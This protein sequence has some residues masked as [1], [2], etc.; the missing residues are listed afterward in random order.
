MASESSSDYEST[1]VRAEGR[2]SMG[3]GPGP[4]LQGG[5][6]GGTYDGMLEAR[7]ARL[8]AD[9][10]HIKNDIGDLKQTLRS[11]S[12][13]VGSLRVDVA[14][15]TERVDHLPSKG[16]IITVLTVTFALVI[17]ALTIMS[18]TGFLAP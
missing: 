15:L 13:D 6:G 14:R 11:T 7:V 9:V 17:G 12:A 2:F 1:V 8:E 5:G 10:E 4:P 16:F 18:K 3:G